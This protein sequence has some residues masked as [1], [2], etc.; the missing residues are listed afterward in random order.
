MTT[1][2]TPSLKT[3]FAK[4]PRETVWVAQE[5]AKKCKKEKV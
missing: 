5:R 3:P 2:T 4:H 1:S